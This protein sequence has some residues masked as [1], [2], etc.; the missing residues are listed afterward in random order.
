MLTV[1]VCLVCIVGLLVGDWQATVSKR[2]CAV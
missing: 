2:V 1:D